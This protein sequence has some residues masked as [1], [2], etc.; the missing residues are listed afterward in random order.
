MSD[1]V[2][3]LPVGWMAGSV[4]VSTVTSSSGRGD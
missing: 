3:T 1:W 4:R 2:H